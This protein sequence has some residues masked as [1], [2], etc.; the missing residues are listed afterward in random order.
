GR[1][2]SWHQAC[3][4]GARLAARLLRVLLFLCLVP[5]AVAAPRLWIEAR[6]DPPS[7]PVN[8]QATL[9]VRFGHAVDVR[10]PR[11]DVPPVRLAELVPLG[12]VASSETLRDGVRYRVLE[13]RFAVLPFA[14]GDLPLGATV[15]GTTPAALPETGGQTRFTLATPELRLAVSPATVSAG[16]LPAHDLQVSAD[17]AT[18]AALRVGEVWTRK[19]LIEAVGVDG[20]VIP[21]PRW[22]TT[23]DWSLQFDPPEVGRRI[24]SGRVI[25]YRR[26]V[27]HAQALHSGRVNFPL[28]RLRWWQVA[29]GQ[30]RDSAPAAASLDVMASV[31]AAPAA[32]RPKGDDV[33]AALKPRGLIE[34]LGWTTPVLLFAVLALVM[35]VVF[36]GPGRDTRHALRC[37]WRRRQLWSALV[38]ACRAND[39]PATRRALLAW[40]AASGLPARSPEVLA[41]GL[42][43][44]GGPLAE[45]LA[46]LEAACYG[47]PGE[48]WNGRALQRALPALARCRRGDSGVGRAGGRICFARGR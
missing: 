24:D 15:S 6:L 30:W 33:A 34:T 37:A 32:A 42:A 46:G 28:P 26:Q 21:A 9:I 36:S 14:S 43:I 22:P 45:A 41:A 23:A 29:T 8:V 20:S 40:A 11:L 44:R 16:W 3:R 47:R 7:V 12:S 39:P 31:P 27:V 18:P 5:G 35:A 48:G 13:R 1:H 2:R 38:A 4:F 19:L 10:S 25:G 17:N